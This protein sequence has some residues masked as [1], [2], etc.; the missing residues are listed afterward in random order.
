[1]K[2]RL[3]I[4]ALLSLFVTMVCAQTKQPTMVDATRD[5]LYP[6][7]IQSTAGYIEHYQHPVTEL[8]CVV[9][10]FLTTSEEYYQYL[11]EID[12]CFLPDGGDMTDYRLWCVFEHPGYIKV[13]VWDSIGN[14]GTDSIWFSI[15]DWVTPME[16]FQM[17]IDGTG[18]AVFSGIATS[19]YL[20]E[21]IFFERSLDTTSWQSAGQMRLVPGP[22]TWRDDDAHFGQD[23]VWNYMTPYTDT[24]GTGV[25]P[26]LV[27]GMMMSTQPAPGGGWYLIMKSILQSRAKDDEIYVYPLFTVDTNGNQHPFVI[28]GEQVVLPASANSYLI[29][30][31]HPDAYYQGA[32][33]KLVDG[34]DNGYEILSYSNKVE[35]PLPEIDA[36]DDHEMIS[37]KVY[38]N[39]SIGTITIEANGLLSVTNVFGQV[40]KQFNVDGQVVFEL[41]R[42]IYFIRN[43]D[44][45][46]KVV[47]QWKL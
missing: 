44:T 10:G 41:P 2:K 28:D 35:N 40:L 3:T 6:E 13:T 7:I 32:V 38:P 12:T 17:E 23:T 19:E 39:P 36:I 26:E 42:G 43:G 1:M 37:F 11:W 16:G 33:A 46:K 15:K 31:R 4:I 25:F 27:P 8:R 45:V 34:K 14:S 20:N 9:W 5:T 29:P 21:Y 18:H 22:W 47:I 24:C 30:G